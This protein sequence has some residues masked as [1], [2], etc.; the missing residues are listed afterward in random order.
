MSATH[1]RRECTPHH[2]QPKG[3]KLHTRAP[4]ET[5]LDCRLV[6]PHSA[7]FRHNFGTLPAVVDALQVEAATGATTHFFFLPLGLPV[8][9]PFGA[10]TYPLLLQ[11]VACRRV[12]E[13][14]NGEF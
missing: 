14:Q 12:V 13:S 4:R 11:Y 3:R 6:L 7:K 8:R 5:L 10:V 9:V 1:H 2:A